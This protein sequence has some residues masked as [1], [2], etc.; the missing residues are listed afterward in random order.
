MSGHDLCLGLER[1]FDKGLETHFL[2]DLVRSQACREVLNGNA[3]QLEI[4]IGIGGLHPAEQHF[5][6][7]SADGLEACGPVMREG[8]QPGGEG[9]SLR[10][11]E[12]G[13]SIRKLMD[14]TCEKPS[15]QRAF[16]RRA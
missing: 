12:A 1:S 6:I 8:R 14:R 4:A 16:D 3:A 10:I 13:A 5:T 9:I 15:F 2:K 7:L 11:G